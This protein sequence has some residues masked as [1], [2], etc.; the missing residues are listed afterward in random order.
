ML[1]TARVYTCCGKSVH[2]ML[3]K[4]TTS[5]SMNKIFASERELSI[6]L[7]NVVAIRGD[8]ITATL[9]AGLHNEGK[10]FLPQVIRSPLLG[11]GTH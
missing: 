7:V 1:N 9:S 4:N 2:H 8:R 5:S 6:T 11:G 3:H 10:N